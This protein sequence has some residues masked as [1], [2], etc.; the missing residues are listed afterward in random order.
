VLLLLEVLG[1]GPV[2]LDLVLLPAELLQVA[3]VQGRGLRH[4][5]QVRAQPGLVLRDRPQLPLPLAGL[6]LRPGPLPAL[7]LRPPQPVLDLLTD[8]AAAGLAGG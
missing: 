3:L 8:D 6:A 7:L 2:L 4:L 1:L 5:L